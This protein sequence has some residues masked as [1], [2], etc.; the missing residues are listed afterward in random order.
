MTWKFIFWYYL[1]NNIN[2]NT[3]CWGND[4]YNDI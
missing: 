1:F 3:K 4:T 2:I